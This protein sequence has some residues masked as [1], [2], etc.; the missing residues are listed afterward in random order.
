MVLGWPNTVD[1]EFNFENGF[2]FLV[3]RVTV[4]L[5]AGIAVINGLVVVVLCP[6]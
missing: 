4:E 2:G 5:G 1:F 6:F 3:R